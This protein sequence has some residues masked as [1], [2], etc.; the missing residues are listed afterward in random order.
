MLTI[1][2]LIFLTAGELHLGRVDD[3]DVIAGVEKRRER[4]LVLALQ[5]TSGN[6]RNSAEHPAVGIDHVPAA[7]RRVLLRGRHERRHSREYLSR[8]NRCK[9]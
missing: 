4:R 8:S 1:D 6:S 7:G 2:L 5:K 9:G 3:D